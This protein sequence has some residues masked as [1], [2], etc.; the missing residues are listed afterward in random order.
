[1]L[2]IDPQAIF[3]VIVF[4][5]GSTFKTVMPENVTE[6]GGYLRYIKS[7]R[8]VLLSDPDVA[9]ITQAIKSSR[10]TPSLKTHRVH[11]QNLRSVHEVKMTEASRTCPK[12]DRPMVLREAKNGSNAG[13]KFWGCSGFPQCKRTSPV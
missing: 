6:S 7:K 4:V 3:S 13:N 12:C 1:M 10:L 8:E 2:G 9:R 5:G 11:V